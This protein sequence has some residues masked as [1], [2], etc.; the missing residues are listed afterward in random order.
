MKRVTIALICFLIFYSSGFPQTFAESKGPGTIQEKTAGMQKFPGYFAFYWDAKTGKLW[1]EIDKWNTEFLYVSSLPAGVGL[2]GIGLNRGQLRKSRVVM[3]HRVGPKVLLVQPNY[4]F[5]AIS[6][7]AEERRAVQESFARSVIW[8]FEVAA[9]EGNRLLV[10]TSAFFLRD[11]HDLTGQLR[12]MDQGSYK[13]DVS[14]SAFYLPRTRNFPKNSEVE[15]TLTVVGDDPGRFVRQV[16]PDPEA[17]TVRQHHSFVELPDAGYKP[18]VWDPRSG[19]YGFEYMDFA[20]PLSEP[21]LKRLVIRHRLQKQNPNMP[22]SEPIKPIVYYVD[23]AAPEPIRSALVEGTSWWNDAF[24]A[25]GYKNAFQVKL[26]P[27]G[28]DP[29]D[30]R[31]NVIQWVHNFNSGGSPP[32]MVRDPRT[33]EIIKGQVAISSLR[34]RQHYLLAEALLAPYEE[35]KLVSPKVQGYALARMRQLAAHEVGHTLGLH[36]NF[37]ASINDRASVMDYP[38]PLVKV[39][40]DGSFDLSDAYTEGI[41]QWDKVAIAYAYQDFQ[42]S[43]GEEKG[44]KDILSRAVSQGLH[45]IQLTTA[46]HPLAYPFDNGSN[47][48][49]ELARVMKIRALALGR[50]S[51]KNLR[52]GALMARLEEVLVP[53]YMFHRYQVEA[54]SEGLG[55]LYFT[56][57]VRG[58]GQK[59]PERVAP[60]EQRRALDALLGT[61]QPDVLAFPESVLNLIPPI[62]V[63]LSSLGHE[64]KVFQ[65]RTGFTFDPLSAA[66][67]TAYITVWMI[68]HPERAARLVEYHALDNSYPGLAEVVDKLIQSTW[69]SQRGSGYHAEIQRVVNNVVVYN[70]MSLGA[71]E[72]AATQVRAVALLKLEELKNWLKKQVSITKDESQRAHFAFAIIQIERF[73]ENPTEV[74]YMKPIDLPPWGDWDLPWLVW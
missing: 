48:V 72:N 53:L 49:D 71:N 66:E 32:S 31:Y 5:R 36:H 56:Y 17:I 42:D 15:V 69:K 28:A 39:N 74:N 68:L 40:Q 30:V 54:V 26:L 4:G 46:G 64:R 35:G 65:R 7:D 44:L 52:E 13:I 24:E 29:M 41:G 11:P 3:F 73:L 27:E 43:A 57:S 45:F 67:A 55:G 47:P 6:D 22:V 37:A 51:E 8:G 14:R 58:D 21:N 59:A 23:P 34:V 20:A 33:G 10:D 62:P 9:E 2:H 1:L 19:L 12:Q 70:M 16:V 63:H 18:R 38:H 25:A 61:I 50:V 60:K